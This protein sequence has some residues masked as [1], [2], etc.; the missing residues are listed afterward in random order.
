M[1]EDD[2]WPATQPDSQQEGCS[3]PQEPTLLLGDR[4]EALWQCLQEASLAATPEKGLATVGQ[5]PARHNPATHLHGS[6]AL[7]CFPSPRAAGREHVC[8]GEAQTW[9][10]IR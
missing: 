9:K 6:T 4:L 2:A 1:G 3:Q 8:W 5:A 7:P 10:G